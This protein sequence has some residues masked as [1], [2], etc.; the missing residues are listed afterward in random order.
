MGC[1]LMSDVDGERHAVSAAVR[2]ILELIE[3]LNADG[4][5]GCDAVDALFV[6]TAETIGSCPDVGDR[7]GMVDGVVLALGTMVET[8]AA[9]RRRHGSH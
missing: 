2:A 9:S 6:A 8:I 3:A 1:V 7:R 5:D 4:L